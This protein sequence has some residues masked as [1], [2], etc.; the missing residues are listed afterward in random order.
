MTIALEHLE[1]VV[2]LVKRS[3]PSSNSEFRSVEFRNYR[4]RCT[5]A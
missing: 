5:V 3:W 4:N 1:I 2:G